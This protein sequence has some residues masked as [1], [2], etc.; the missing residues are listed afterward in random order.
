MMSVMQRSGA[1]STV[2]DTTVAL[3]YWLLKNLET[4]LPSKDILV[5]PCRHYIVPDSAYRLN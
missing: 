5:V 1:F 2:D 4:A 3:S